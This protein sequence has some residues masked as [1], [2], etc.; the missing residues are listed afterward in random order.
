MN[1]RSFNKVKTAII[2][3]VI[4]AFC[5]TKGIDLVKTRDL[6]KDLHFYDVEEKQLDNNDTDDLIDINTASLDELQTLYRIGPSLA[7]KI[8]DYREMYGSFSTTE[9][10]KE[11]S[12]IGDA[13]YEKIKDKI[14]VSNN[15]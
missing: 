5:I 7:Q 14:K 9:E 2:S 15:E 13:T 4:L 3:C 12:G 10:I 8:I 11:I 1:K 6:E